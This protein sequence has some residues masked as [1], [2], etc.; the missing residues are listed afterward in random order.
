MKA[1]RIWCFF[2]WR[3]VVRASFLKEMDSI[4]V[5]AIR[6]NVQHTHS[7]L[8]AKLKEPPDPDD[9][10]S[11]LCRISKKYD[12]CGSREYS[13]KG[14]KWTF[15]PE[16]FCCSKTACFYG[17]CGSW[18]H[19]NW[20]LCSSSIIYHDEYSYG[21]CNCKRFQENCDVNAICVH[22]N[23]E[24]GGAYCQCKEGYWGD[25]KS[26]KIDFCQLQP[27]GAGTCTRT[28]EGYKCDCPETH[29]LIVVEDKE[30]CKAKPDF[31]AEEPCGP[32]SMVENC[33][34]TDDSYE[35]VCK[36]G[37]EVRNGR[38]EEIDL[39]ADK[40][41]GPDEGVHECVTERQP[42]LR[43]R[44]TCKAG[45]DLT[46][47]PDGVSQKCLKNFCYEEPC[48]T[49]DLV[50][51]C[52]S[53][54]Y[55]YSCLCAAGAMV[56]VING[57][58]KCIKADLCRNDPC[59]PETAVIQC[60]SHGTSYR[61]LCKAGYT[62]VFVNGKSSCQKGDPCTLNMCGGNEAV[63]EC[64]T[65]G[66]AYG[67]TCKPGYSIAIKHGQKFC[68]PE[69]EC[70]SHCGSAA[71]VKSCEILDSGGYQCTCNPGYVMRYSDYVKGCVEGNQCSLNP[72]GEQEAV[73]RCIPEGDTYDC[74][75]NPGF[76]K[77]VLPDGNFICA[78]PA[79][80]V[81][82]PCGSSDAVDACIAGTSTYTCRCKDGYT[83][84][85][86][87]S[88]LQCLPESTDQTD[89]DSK[90]KPEDNKGR[91]SKGTIALVV[92]GCVALL[93]IIAG[94]I[95]YARNRGGERDDEDLAPPPR[96]TR[97]R[98]LSS[99]G[100]GFENASWA[101]SVSMI[102]SAPAPPPSGGIWS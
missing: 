42:K 81:G 24:D 1:N 4:F 101:S 53:K 62:E 48:G 75:C 68:N 77:R 31:C 9:E 90:H 39:C 25:G 47:L 55:G 17:S 60:Y 66:T 95:S 94:G 96:S 41:C 99:M 49:R 36:Q 22:A 6:Q 92:V 85:S 82:N 93:G 56:Q 63:Q 43:Y 71:A 37:Y 21:K 73:Q 74:E 3:M 2:A 58:E 30:T 57:K 79:S 64:T 34:N 44:C 18:C 40:P 69:E 50:E 80:C 70:A 26:C 102:P 8:L 46:T 29:K 86:I 38:C 12:A 28:D 5:S 98:R 10:N 76:V 54:A 87:G 61:C 14:L 7:A 84:Q 91:Y 67:C 78:D 89:F 59:G 100:E 13:D 27:C 20:A 72:C 11:W 65:D 23:R 45:F 33:V 19:D 15:C 35:C 16:D 32:P 52:K 51:S 88:K 97:E 83:P